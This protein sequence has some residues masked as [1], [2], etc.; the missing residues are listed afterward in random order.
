MKHPFFYNG[1]LYQWECTYDNPYY[2]RESHYKIYTEEESYST[3][4]KAI[5]AEFELEN[6]PPK[7]KYDDLWKNGK[8]TIEDS[9]RGY[10]KFDYNESEDCF[11]LIRKQ[12]YDD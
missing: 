11:E 12:G 4:K 2:G 5:I 9:I 7:C 3:A 10:Y 8:G 1:I 6:V